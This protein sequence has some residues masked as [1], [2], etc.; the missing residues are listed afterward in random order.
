MTADVAAIQ[1]RLAAG[2]AAGAQALADRLLRAPALPAE[3]RA[4]ALW[5]RARAH[6]ALGAP[7]AAIADLEAA[8]TLTPADA[9]I[10]N[11]LGV[12]RT[13]AGQPG[14]AAAAF[15]HAVAIDPRS[16]R[17]WNNLGNSLRTAGRLADAASA[18]TEAVAV[19]PDYT[20]AL[21]NLAAAQRDL[22]DDAAAQASLE[23]A[24]A[25]DPRHPGALLALGALARHQG[26]LDRAA[27]LFA[28]A[29]QADP[30]DAKPCL[31]LAS[32]LAERD[33]LPMARQLYAEALAR[34]PTQ[35]RALLG[36]QL[37]LPMVPASGA[38]VAAARAGFEAGLAALE[39]S[40]PPV[41]RGLAAATVLDGLPWS[42]FLLAYQGGD[43]RPLQ[44]R[45]AALVGAALEA[46]AP[47]WRAPLPA[48]ARGDRRLRVGFASYF[49]RDGTAGRYFEHWITDLDPA[50]FEVTLYH[51][52]PGADA[53]FERLRARADTVRLCPRWP[54][55]RI[56]P[57]IRDDALDAL[58]YTEL[59][60]EATTFA[61]AALRLAPLQ[62][63]AWG[64]PVTTGHPT[65]DVFFSSGAM[66][67]QDGD[68][69][70]TE[71]LIRL[72]G[73]GTRYAQ[74][75]PP[76]DADRG[77]FGLPAAAFL[78]LCP[79]SLFKIHPDNDA[80]YARVLAAAPA[81]HLVL[82]EGRHPASTAKFRRRLETALARAGVAPE[83]RIHVL[84]QC[85][86][87]D[88]LR[89]NRVCDAM[90]DTL[91]WSGGNT[92]LDAIAC[93]LPLVTLPG[94]F[95][96]G[97]QS[98]GMLRLMGVEELIAR[99]AGHYVDL[100]TRLAG[101]AAWRA[102]CSARIVAGKAL[103]FD[104]GEPTAALAAFL[105]EAAGASD[106]VRPTAS[107]G[108]PPE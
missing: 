3:A 63:A 96:R 73:I 9:R 59:G 101:D 34:D 102:A 16:A 20:L 28:R 38:E 78:F 31:Q 105:L 64:H 69:H 15:E 77:R 93:G 50:S 66:E 97:R 108:A 1:A 32:T 94:R 89:V 25:I 71:R 23:R 74:P 8:A 49:F 17:A 48:H 88:Y 6:E 7:A 27:A 68:A 90:L 84:P 79:Q 104:R 21:T 13:I 40:L 103:L 56:A 26:S 45:Y 58:V 76:A 55:S 10:W 37:T 65:I 62:C 29:A 86:H 41:V 67:P 82:F 19:K 33:D 70:Y 100:A 95:M 36:A 46:A 81:A 83:G 30:K 80:L 22:G 11:E 43:D 24:L 5:L 14:A 61:L 98:A 92:S 106:G 53:L 85:G 75:V 91:H 2:D 54:V 18:F 39:S 52:H 87:D 107:G 44:A 42:N 60:M 57:A 4:T 51:M 35:I 47:A 72:P 12:L 99:D